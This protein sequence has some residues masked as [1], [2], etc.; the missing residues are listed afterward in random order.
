[1]GAGP[2]GDAVFLYFHKFNPRFAR[3]IFLAAQFGF[4]LLFIPYSREKLLVIR[5]C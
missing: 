5:N 4:G 3:A 2:T 1:M